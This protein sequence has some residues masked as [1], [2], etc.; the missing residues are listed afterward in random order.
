MIKSVYFVSSD[1]F[2]KYD[3]GKGFEKVIKN[4]KK[5]KKSNRK[6]GGK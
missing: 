5:T 6:K 1:Y 4:S 2:S 3:R